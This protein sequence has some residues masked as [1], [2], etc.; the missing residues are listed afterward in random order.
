VGVL[1]WGSELFPYGA[2]GNLGEDP[3]GGADSVGPVGGAPQGGCPVREG[4]G[5]PD[6]VLVGAVCRVAVPGRELAPTFC[7]RKAADSSSHRAR[8]RRASALRERDS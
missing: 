8:L 3:E 5:E 7:W 1:G 4:V 6:E 2:V